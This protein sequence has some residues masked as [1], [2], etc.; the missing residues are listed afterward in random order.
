L[1]SVS[2]PGTSTAA[3]IPCIARPAISTSSVGAAAHPMEATVNTA[4][5]I[6]YTR[7]APDRSLSAPPP[8]IRDAN[9]S[10]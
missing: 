6:T 1:S 5:P 9:V 7:L 4:N 3:P 8:R 2:E 10:V